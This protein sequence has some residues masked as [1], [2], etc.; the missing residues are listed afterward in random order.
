MRTAIH[1]ILLMK[2]RS[3]FTYILS[4][5]ALIGLVSCQ[6]VIDVETED[7]EPILVVDAWLTN[8]S[9]EQSI[10]LSRSQPYFDNSVPPYVEDAQVVVENLTQNQT[11][12]FELAENGRYSWTP[13]TGESVGQ[14]EDQFRLTITVN[15]QEYLSF[16]TMGRVAQVDSIP[17]EFRDDEPIGPDG[18]YAQ[19]FARDIPGRGDAY[20]IKTFKNGSFLNKPQ[21]MNISYDGGIDDNTQL[22]GLT[23]I[24]PI[25]ELVNR[26]PDEDNPDDDIMIPPYKE[27]DSIRVEIHSITDEAFLFLETARDQM[28]NG[29]NT[30]F[31][32]PIANSPGNIDRSGGGTAPLGIFCVSAVSSLGKVID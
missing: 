16:S 24:A 32:I 28:T 31:T 23:F 30:I 14:V 3:L 11:Y 29:D 2:N 19:V 12:T 22:D 17:H 26:V 13:E 27:G 8:Q 7:V 20:W 25:R 6:D 10:Y 9:T 15:N 5:L 4:L 18:I 21:E 1:H